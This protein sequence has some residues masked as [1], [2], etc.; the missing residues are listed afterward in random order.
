MVECTG[1]ENR[2][3]PTVP[4]EFK[5]HPLRHFVPSGDKRRMSKALTSTPLIDFKADVEGSCL[6]AAI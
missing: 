1:L 5:S 4:R 3:G 2:Q 6:D